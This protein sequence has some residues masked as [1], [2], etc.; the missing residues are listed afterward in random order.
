LAA[1]ALDHGLKLCIIFSRIREEMELGHTIR[2]SIK[3][4][5]NKALS[6]IL[7]GNITTLIASLV[8]YFFGSGTIKGFAQTLG[9]GILLS[10]F[11]ALVVS[12][13]LL[14]SLHA[15]LPDKPEL[16]CRVKSAKKEVKA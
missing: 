9:L 15:L 5:F 2:V 6:A 10:M 12:R 13:L 14:T 8:L 11:S 7:D 1:E 4:G 3:D 16:Y